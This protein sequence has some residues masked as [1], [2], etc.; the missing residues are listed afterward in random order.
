MPFLRREFLRCVIDAAGLGTCEGRL[1][2]ELAPTVS[3]CRQRSA[4]MDCSSWS[5]DIMHS[6]GGRTKRETD[7]SCHFFDR[8]STKVNQRAELMASTWYLVPVLSVQYKPWT[9]ILGPAGAE[10]RPAAPDR[11]DSCTLPVGNRHSIMKLYLSGSY[12]YRQHWRRNEAKL[13]SFAVVH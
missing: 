13:C 6:R 11:P 3:R 7:C 4:S 1:R 2:L 9:T 8:S 5:A 10:P 12:R